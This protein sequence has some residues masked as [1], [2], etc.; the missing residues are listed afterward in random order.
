ML[1]KVVIIDACRSANA[2]ASR[3]SFAH[4]RIDLLAAEI[5]KALLARN[6]NVDPRM[7]EDVR[8]GSVVQ[9]Q[10]IRG[11]GKGIAGL[12]GLPD[13]IPGSGT[14]RQCG[15]SMDTFQQIAAFI[16]TGMIDIGIALGADKMAQTLVR[17][18]YDV[19]G[20]LPGAGDTPEAS[21]VQLSMEPDHFEVY[22]KPFPDYIL[23]APRMVG[24][25]QTAQNI[26]EVYGLTRA[27]LDQYAYKSHIKAANATAGGKFKDEIIPIK[28]H[29]PLFNEKKEVIPDQLGDEFVFDRDECIRPD[30]TPEALAKLSPL[31]IVQ[32]YSPEGKEVVITAG[33][34]CP[35]ND[36]AVAV[37]VMSEKKANE[38]GLKPLARVKSMAVAGTKP[39]L[40]GIGPIPASKK[41]LAKAGLKA[42]DIDLC[43]FNE[44]FASQAIA[45]VK[46]IGVNPDVVNVNGGAL[47]LGHPLGQ[48]G[49]RL[50]TTM[51]HE[52]KRRRDVRYG[53]A[54]M[55]IG[56][57]QGIATI[58]EKC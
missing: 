48:S 6:P 42:S 28:T 4:K 7:V 52:M 9:G 50:L 29:K 45:S 15:S 40:M 17:L 5:L 55:C 3:G 46:D 19:P 41:A 26:A 56:G 18:S 8:I 10:L 44:A 54:T 22:S 23:K 30:T 49:C 39:Q 53:L 47:A 11:G 1:E 37:L 34:S 51:V 57:G 31:K 20:I 58:L 12:A 2:R 24:M 25:P 38:L 21:D 43:E 36:S 35:T 33:N 14:N 27:E 13:T 32:T 16:A